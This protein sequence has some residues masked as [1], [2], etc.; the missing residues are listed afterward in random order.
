[1]IL[2]SGPLGATRVAG[3]GVFSVVFK[4]P[5]TELAG[6]SQAAGFWGAF[7]KLAGFDALVVQGIAPSWSYLTIHDGGAELRDARQLLG[8][9]TWQTEEAIAEELGVR[10]TRMSVFAIGP[11]GE[12]QVRYASLVG[13]KGHVVAHNGI[14]AVLGAKRLKAIAVVRGSQAVAIHD[15]ARLAAAASRLLDHATNEFAGGLIAQFGTGG[16]VPGVYATGQLPVKNYTTNLFEGANDLSG[17]TL[18]A[19]HEI[20]PHPCWACGVAHVK[21]VKVLEGPYAGVEGEEPEYEGL[22]G[23]G[24]QIGNAD[25]ERW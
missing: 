18:R 6:A 8:L 15:E 3:T 24:S 20:T 9:D 10:P 22:A 14:G 25:L 5:M 1:V 2:A 23:W 21:M 4:G 12:N 11:A 13:D 16:L 17:Q 19:R 7:L